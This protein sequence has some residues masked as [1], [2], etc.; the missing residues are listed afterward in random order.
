MIYLGKKHLRIQLAMYIFSALVNA[1]AKSWEGFALCSAA[2]ALWF[3]FI[4]E[5][6]D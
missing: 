1:W 2:A 3:Y 6:G 4:L 5:C